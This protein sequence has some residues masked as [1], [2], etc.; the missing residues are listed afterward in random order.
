MYLFVALFLGS[1]P[2]INYNGS[3]QNHH[4]SFVTDKSSFSSEDSGEVS[5]QKFVKIWS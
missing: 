5:R 3:R 4:C 1:E 2:I